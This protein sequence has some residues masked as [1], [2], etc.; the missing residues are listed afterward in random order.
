MEGKKETSKI[1]EFR[2]LKFRFIPWFTILPTGPNFNYAA[3]CQTHLLCMGNHVYGLL[4]PKPLPPPQAPLPSSAAISIT[5]PATPAPL[6]QQVTVRDAALPTGTMTST[7]A[8]NTTGGNTSEDTTNYDPNMTGNNILII[9]PQ[10][11]ENTAPDMLE[12]PSTADTAATQSDGEVVGTNIAAPVTGSE[13]EPSP[14]LELNTLLAVGSVDEPTPQPPDDT[15][16]DSSVVNLDKT[17]ANVVT[18]FSGILTKECRV[19][20]K[21]LD[22]SAIATAIPSTSKIKNTKEDTSSTDSGKDTLSDPSSTDSDETPLS[23][24]FN[25]D[26]GR[27]RRRTKKVKYEESSPCSDSDSSFK[28]IPKKCFKPHPRLGPSADRFWAYK[29]SCATVNVSSTEPVQSTATAP[30][31]ESELQQDTAGKKENQNDVPSTS[32]M[33]SQ[34]HQTDQDNTTV[35]PNDAPSLRSNDKPAP[36]GRLSVT[37]HGLHKPKKDRRFKCKECKFVATSHKESN[38]HHK[39]KHDKCYCN[40]CGKAWN[41][42]S[43]LAPHVYSHRDELPFPCS[44]YELKFAFEG[45]LKQHRFKHHTLSAFPCSKCDKTYKQEGKLIKHLKVH[46]NKT[47]SCTD[48]KYS[49]QDPRN[50]KHHVKLH[51]DSFPY[52]CDSCN[53]FFRFWMQKKHHVFLGSANTSS[54]EF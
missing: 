24:L 27:P 54:E 37:H 44:D 53:K 2:E 5:T 46:E 30:L 6:Q 35:S 32:G 40:I 31:N 18:Q 41:T 28:K 52:M 33:T 39:D 25:Q 15:S 42:P 20:L 49:T 12:V 19:V 43:T 29:H 1:I 34:N 51:M 11:M 45:Q 47:Y 26:W 13:I 17:T 8:E 16:N 48:C 7:E 21:T 23:Q 10:N 9:T 3:A 14:N 4:L 50:L 38:D 36:L 22:I